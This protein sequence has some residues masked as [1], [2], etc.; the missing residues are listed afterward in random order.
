M[1]PPAE[2]KVRRRRP[3]SCREE[4]QHRRLLPWS[5][6]QDI[7]KHHDQRS[8]RRCQDRRPSL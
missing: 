4:G 2:K 5:G 6:A 1:T 8:R 3:R 7:S